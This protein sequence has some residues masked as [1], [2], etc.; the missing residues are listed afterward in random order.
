VTDSAAP[1]RFLAP[2]IGIALVFAGLGPPIGGATFVPLALLLKAPAAAGAF[3]LSA[4]VASLFGHW[5]MLFAAY[6]VGLGPATA[7][8]VLYALWDAAAPERWPRALIAAVIGGFAAYAVALRLA[9]LGASLDMMFDTNFD[10]PTVQSISVTAAAPA[11]PISRGSGLIHAFV[12]SGAVAGLVCAM[13]A[14]LIGL[15]MKP[16][17][18]RSGTEGAR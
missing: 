13:A 9:A 1:R 18:V 3:A 12:A 15:T 8:G 7:T 10:A 17:P 16:G 4:V 14:S 5:I 11:E 2:F 6:V